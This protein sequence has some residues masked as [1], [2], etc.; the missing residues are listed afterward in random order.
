[1]FSQSSTEIKNVM[2]STFLG[3]YVDFFNKTDF[4]LNFDSLKVTIIWILGLFILS[5]WSLKGKRLFKLPKITKNK[6]CLKGMIKNY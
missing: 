4:T 1:M 6:F 5:Y 2:E 3:V